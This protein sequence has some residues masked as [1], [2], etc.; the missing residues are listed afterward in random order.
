MF[1]DVG[2]WF[3]QKL[4]VRQ[5]AVGLGAGV[6][7]DVGAACL[8]N[9]RCGKGRLVV[10]LGIS[11]E[12]TFQCG[13]VR[14]ILALVCWRCWGGMLKKPPVSGR[15]GFVLVLAGP[16]CPL[17]WCTGGP[18]Q[19]VKL[20]EH[21]VSSYWLMNGWKH[22]KGMHTGFAIPDC[23]MFRPLCNTHIHK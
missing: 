17:R 6:F 13:K 18:R 22:S 9:F 2:A 4:S 3:I 10:G 12:K 19:D 11:A 14:L 8:N 16:R 15:K 7:G 5:R 1:G 20:P 21:V 23:L